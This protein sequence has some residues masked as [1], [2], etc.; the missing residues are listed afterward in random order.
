[1]EQGDQQMKEEPGL[2]HFEGRS[3]RGFHHHACLVMLSSGFLVLEQLRAKESPVKPG[4]KGSP[5]PRITVP[6]IRR[7]L[8]Q[9]LRP[10]ARPDCAYCNPLCRPFDQRSQTLTE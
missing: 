10:M 6:A 7:A 4:K 1:V 3:W 2:N 5:P 9:L 8:Q